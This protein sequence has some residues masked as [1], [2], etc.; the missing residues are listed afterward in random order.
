MKCPRDNTPLSLFEHTDEIELDGCPYCHG[1]WLDRGELEAIQTRTS[2]VPNPDSKLQ[3]SVTASIEGAKQLHA[4]AIKCPKCGTE[5]VLREYGLG[6][7][8]VVDACPN[9]CGIWLDE[10]EL[11]LLERFYEGSIV[12]AREV[13]PLPLQVR[14]LIH[15]LFQRMKKTPPKRP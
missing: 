6:C 13:V 3:D 8:T 5:M 11:E 4:S 12:D 9:A 2:S 10:K 1:M 15:E 7:Q 14:L